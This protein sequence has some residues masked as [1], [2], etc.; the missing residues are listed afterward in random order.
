MGCAALGG[1]I[2]AFTIAVNS[3]AFGISFG[4]VTL[5]DVA[6]MGNC[7]GLSALLTI[8]DVAAMGNC[9]GS[10]ALSFDLGLGCCVLSG[11]VHTLIIPG[12]PII[13]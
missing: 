13:N 2:V 7:F 5:V 11:G 8:V 12:D 3:V 10:S 4:L 9:F 1:S 6:L